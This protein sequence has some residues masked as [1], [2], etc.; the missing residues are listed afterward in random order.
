M[1]TPAKGLPAGSTMTVVV[2][3][4]A[5]PAEVKV[6]G[7]L[8]VELHD[9]RHH[10]LGRPDRG[11]GVVVPRQRLSERQGDVSTSESP[12]ARPSRRSRTVVL[13]S[14]QVHGPGCQ[15]RI[16]GRAAPMSTLPL[17]LE[18]RQVRRRTAN[19][20]SAARRPTSPIERT[21]S[22][23]VQRARR[24]VSQAP[25]DPGS[26]AVVV[27][28]VPVPGGRARSSRRR[29]TAQRSRARPVRRITAAVLEE[30]LPQHLG[31]RPRALPPVVRRRRRTSRAGGTSGCRRGSRRT[32]SGSG[33]AHTAA[34]PPSS[35]S[36]RTT[37]STRR[38][39][40]SGRTPS[41]IPTSGPGHRRPT[42]VAR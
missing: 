11:V 41:C 38:E 20:S 19:A 22:V 36:R 5:H 13:V 14:R 28:A 3:Y 1:V 42:S 7:L 6:A 26:A 29:R 23:Y 39:T 17:V 10:G 4:A 8:G 31:G 12:P 16:G 35:S 34:G 9:H 37:R 18:H 32:P 2:T 15:R 24:D 33:P 21:G 25:D 40:T 27:R 30:P